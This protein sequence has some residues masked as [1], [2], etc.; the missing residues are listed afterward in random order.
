MLTTG[1]D[2]VIENVPIL[3]LDLPTAC[4]QFDEERGRTQFRRKEKKTSVDWENILWKKKKRKE[5]TRRW[6]Y[7]IILAIQIIYE[8]WVAIRFLSFATLRYTSRVP[9]FP[10][11]CIRFFIF[12]WPH[13]FCPIFNT[14]IDSKL[15][16]DQYFY[17]L[18]SLLFQRN[19]CN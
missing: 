12:W 16:W 5:K 7:D 8:A 6:K 4:L 14:F 3:T 13:L 1:F 2:V 9:S 18:I 19:Y 15:A 10:S 17:T 11:D